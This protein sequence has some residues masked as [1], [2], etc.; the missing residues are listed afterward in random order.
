MKVKMN[1]PDLSTN[2]AE[3]GIVRWLIEPGQPVRRG[4]PIVEV[5]TDKAVMEVESI[6]TGIL[7][8]THAAP[9]DNVAV[10]QVIATIEVAES[11]T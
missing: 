11:T 7:D 8:E 4:Q 1:M 6:A 3:I 5:Q 2:E 10:G 9:E